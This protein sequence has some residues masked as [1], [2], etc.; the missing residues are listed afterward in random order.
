MALKLDLSG[1]V[2]LITGATSGIGAQQARALTA[3]GASVVLIGR[4]EDRLKELA[5]EIRDSGAK[6]EYLAADL[7][8]EGQ[9]DIIVGASLNFFGRVDILCNTAGVNLRQHADDVTSESWD[10]T[11]TLNLKVPFMLAQKLVPNMR[12]RGWGKII[13]VASLQSERA[14]ANGIAYG[15]SKGGIS[16]LTRA[17]AEAWSKDGIGCNA[18]APGFF[19]TELTAPVF[20]QSELADKLAQQTAIGRNGNLEDL[21]G[22]CV[23]LAS[24]ASD[25][26]TGQTLYIDGGFTAK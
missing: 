6:A 3:A 10:Q 2:A 14:F 15:A 5:K 16:Q 9:W 7:S 18:I 20:E 21:D 17:M 22:P 13:N 23:F 19:P 12:E 1:K 8:D 11:L 24:H 26:V 25:Y 4:R